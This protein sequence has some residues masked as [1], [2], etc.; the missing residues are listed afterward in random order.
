MSLI[1]L[2]Q[3]EDICFRIDLLRPYAHWIT[4]QV[5]SKRFDTRFLL[6]RMPSN[7]IP[8]HDSIELTDSLWITPADA[9]VRQK[10]GELL[11]M[12]PTLKTMEE[13]ADFSSVDQLFTEAASREIQ[14]ILPQTFTTS[15]GFGVKLPH[16][17]EYTL[18][19]FK[20]PP[21]PDEPSRIVMVNGRWQ[22]VRVEK[23]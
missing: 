9:L 21:R 18:T 23:Q 8:V 4:P 15:D 16:D 2:A 3:A 7:Q 17:P 11:L 1:D 22:T 19:D 20:L 14:P 10:A 13:L 12:P 6:A 5:E